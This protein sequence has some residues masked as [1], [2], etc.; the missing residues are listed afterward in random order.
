MQF[1]S[2]LT[3]LP[4]TVIDDVIEGVVEVKVITARS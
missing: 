2:S 1:S 4:I 3:N